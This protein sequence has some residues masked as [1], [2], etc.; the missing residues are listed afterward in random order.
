MLVE[1]VVIDLEQGKITRIHDFCM[2]FEQLK[3][4]MLALKDKYPT[5]VIIPLHEK[6]LKSQVLHKIVEG[7]NECE[8]LKK[9]YIALSADETNYQ[10]ALKL[11]EKFEVPCEVVWCNRPEVLEI[12]GELQSRGLDISSTCGKGRDLWLTIGIASLELYAFAV[13]D[14]DIETYSAM[15]PTKLL[16]TVVEPTLDFWFSKGYYAR[17]NFD[18]KT[19]YGR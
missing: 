19:M 18:T 14:A 10:R 12:L 7:L 16:Y 3:A 13:H 4:R 5:G 1:V 15:L 6:D 11:A 8:Y 2:N 9:V 17:V